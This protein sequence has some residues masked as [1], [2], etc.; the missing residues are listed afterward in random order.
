MGPRSY[1]R[2][3]AVHTFAVQTFAVP[4]QWGRVLMNAEITHIV[5][6][7]PHSQTASMGPRS[8]ERGNPYPASWIH[9]HCCS[10]NGAAF[11]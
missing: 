10:F 1:E 3:N 2:G 4:L 9:I 7:L 6:C 11:L 5:L 8:Y